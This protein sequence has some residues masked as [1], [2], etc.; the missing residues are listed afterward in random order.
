MQN[1]ADLKM[2]SGFVGFLQNLLKKSKVPSD[3]YKREQYSSH[4]QKTVAA[5]VNLN[6]DTNGSVMGLSRPSWK[7]HIIFSLRK[8]PPLCHSI[9][10]TAPTT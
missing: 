9:L 8:Q 5:I 2:E 3:D 10:Q 6:K 7:G 4:I 1:C